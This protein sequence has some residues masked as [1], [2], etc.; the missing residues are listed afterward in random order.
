MPPADGRDPRE[1]DRI[2]R[3]FVSAGRVRG[4]RVTEYTFLK[5]PLF[6]EKSR[7]GRGRERD[8]LV[9][10]EWTLG[11]TR[12]ETGNKHEIPLADRH[13]SIRPSGRDWTIS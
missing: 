3:K 13:S 5:C 8:L 9:P 6:H 11:L 2:G 4:E 1:R 12:D 7:G 10:M